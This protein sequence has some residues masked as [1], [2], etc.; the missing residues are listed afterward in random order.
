MNT[1][2]FSRIPDRDNP[3]CI[4]EFVGRSTIDK[5]LVG[6]GRCVDLSLVGIIIFF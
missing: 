5:L 1:R 3:G 2:L 4:V 6:L